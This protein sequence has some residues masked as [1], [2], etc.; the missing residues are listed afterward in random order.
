MYLCVCV[1]KLS[2]PFRMSASCCLLLACL[3]TLL[4]DDVQG[5]VDCNKD[6]IKQEHRK[7]NT[8]VKVLDNPAYKDV[9]V[10]ACY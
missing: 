4:N 2:V 5:Q 3:R 7:G 6:S 9:E 10:L 1:H 8:V